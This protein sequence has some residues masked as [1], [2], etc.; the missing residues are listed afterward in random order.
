MTLP[1][2][3]ILFEDNHQIVVN[4]PAGVLTQP[5]DTGNES[6]EELVKAWIKIKYNKQGNVFIGTVHRIDKPVSGVVLFARTSKAL[7]RLNDSMRQ[8]QAHKMY[9]ATVEGRVVDSQGTLE[10]Y[11]VHD[12]YH[13]RV[14]HSKD[15]AGKLCRLHYRVLDQKADTAVVEIIL[16]TGRYHQIRAQMSAIGHPVVGDRKYGSRQRHQDDAI[17]LHH[18]R[19]QIPHPITGELQT[20]EAPPPQR[21]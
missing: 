20:F 2:L 21:F 15:P 1:S 4:K 13:A 9:L 3:E 5:D 17:A 16:E 19:L 10:H 11:L 7:S 6:L 8:K 12:D 18:Y 14:T